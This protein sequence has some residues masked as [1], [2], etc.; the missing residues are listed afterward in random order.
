MTDYHSMVTPYL[1]TLRHGKLTP[2]TITTY[3]NNLNHSID[4]LIAGGYEPNEAY[5]SALEA[6]LAQR[7]A[8]STTQKRVSLARRFFT[9]AQKGQ[10]IMTT[11]DEIA[12]NEN[13]PE[14]QSS[15]SQE[16][17]TGDNLP[18]EA[19]SNPSSPTVDAPNITRPADPIMPPQ[20][21]EEEAG[22]HEHNTGRP[23]K[24]PEGRTRKLTIYL[25]PA[26]DADVKDLA[27]I[28]RLSTPD[29]IFRLIER[30]RDRRADALNTFRALE[31]D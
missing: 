22:A 14:A 15:T 31:E 28:Q 20:E 6:N 9:W 29:Y 25:T 24:S 19:I 13:I 27:R 3:T 10:M 11:L 2:D 30:E 8:K 12:S 7:L 17:I 23:R 4:F 16:E 21:E 18:E 26:L 1:A 5:Y